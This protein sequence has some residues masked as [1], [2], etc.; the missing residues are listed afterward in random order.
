MR[1]G[2]RVALL[3]RYPEHDPAMPQRIPNLG[4]RMVEASLLA[5]GLAGLEVRVWDLEPLGPSAAIVAAEVIR[6][7]PDVVGLSMFLWSLPFLL[8]VAALVKAD[9]PQ[10]LVVLGGPSARPVMLDMPPHDADAA[11][12]DVLV[13][14]EGGCVEVDGELN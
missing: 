12:A 14:N 5:S 9:D 3:A 8:E 13:I 10:R 11:S 7:D 1:A 2:R 6:F 4:L